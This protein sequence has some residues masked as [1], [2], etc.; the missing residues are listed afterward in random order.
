VEMHYHDALKSAIDFEMKG[1]EFYLAAV[2]RTADAFTK[3]TLQFLANEELRHIEKIEKFSQSLLEQTDF[4]LEKETESDLPLRAK[5]YVDRVLHEKA[6]EISAQS[7]DIEIY[8]LALDVENSGY[9]MYKNAFESNS[10]ENLKKFF[11]FLMQE[12]KIH[13]DLLSSSKKYLA[14]PS[15][16][17]EAFGGWI[18]G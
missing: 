11:R 6:K 2:G 17:F 1:E 7:S 4:D 13:A 16:Y 3:N 9:I 14:D 12:E 10:H 18:F 8:D 15:Y 5:E